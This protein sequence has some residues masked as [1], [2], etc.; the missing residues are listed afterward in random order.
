MKGIERVDTRVLE[1]GQIRLRFRLTEEAHELVTL[2]LCA[3]PYGHTGAA[4]DAI[5]TSYH[6]GHPTSLTLGSP[7]VGGRRFLVRLFPDQYENVRSALDLARDTTAT[8]ANALVLMCA[9]FVVTYQDEF[10]SNN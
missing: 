8:D 6:A 9:A 7:A 2:A 5:A 10:S 3:T 4:L 1:S